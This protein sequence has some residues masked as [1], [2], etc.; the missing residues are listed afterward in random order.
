MSVAP[1]FIEPVFADHIVGIFHHFVYCDDALCH[2]V[3]T[4]DLGCRRN[5]ALHKIQA[6]SYG[7]PRYFAAMEEVVPPQTICFPSLEKKSA[8]IRLGNRPD[9]KVA[10]KAYSSGL[11]CGFL[12]RRRWHRPPASHRTVCSPRQ[13][14]WWITDLAAYPATDIVS[15]N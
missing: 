1:L 9:W 14:E 3:H 15:M 13:S 11:S 8:I 4:F 10:R 12:P 2:Q 7:F 6:G 5:V